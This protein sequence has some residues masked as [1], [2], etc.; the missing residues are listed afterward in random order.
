MTIV[1]LQITED[2]GYQLIVFDPANRSSESV[3]DLGHHKGRIRASTAAQLLK[4]Y[5][6]DAKTLRKHGEFEV[7]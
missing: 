3:M 6:R 5:T 2:G 7:L 1:G 4:F